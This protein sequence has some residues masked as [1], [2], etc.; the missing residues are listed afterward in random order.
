MLVEEELCRAQPE[1]RKGVRQP[2]GKRATPG[3]FGKKHTKP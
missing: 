2:V 3:A 1:E